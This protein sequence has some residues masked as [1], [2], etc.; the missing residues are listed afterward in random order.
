MRTIIRSCE[1]L[2]AAYS[3]LVCLK[4][5]SPLEQ[6]DFQKLSLQL[7]RDQTSWYH[8]SNFNTGAIM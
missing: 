4:L 3:L 5:H 6:M 8:E 1:S 7:L 2:C